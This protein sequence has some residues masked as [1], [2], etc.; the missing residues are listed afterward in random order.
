MFMQSEGHSQSER[1][2]LVE[3][4]SGV[5]GND[6][7]SEEIGRVLCTMG[8]ELSKREGVFFPL[9]AVQ[10]KVGIIDYSCFTQ[11]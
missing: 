11:I 8:G 4:D 1:L 9:V 3:M 6:P 2:N 7:S 5:K 10:F